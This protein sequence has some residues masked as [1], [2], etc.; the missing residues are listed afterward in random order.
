MKEITTEFLPCPECGA[1]A[2]G[3]ETCHDRFH[4]LL[5]FDYQDQGYFAV[6]HLLVLTFMTQHAD[7]LTDE[8]FHSSRAA[9]SA[10]AAGKWPDT[11]VQQQ[12]QTRLENRAQF[13][14]TA[15]FVRKSSQLR[16][17]IAWTR[18]VFDVD[19]SGVS[20]YVQTVEAWASAVAH[21]LESAT[22][23]P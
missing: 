10:F 22:A 20:A 13:D 6:H 12:A 8:A 4:E 23:S 17:R 7:A 21:D 11:H 16:Q 1:F 18:T 14:G 5:I 9:L 15:Q 19:F 3:I 2:E